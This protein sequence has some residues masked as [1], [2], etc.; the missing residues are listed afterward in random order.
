MEKFQTKVE[1]LIKDC[2]T[3]AGL[4]KPGISADDADLIVLSIPYDGESNDRKGSYLAPQAIR[5][6][7]GTVSPTNEYFESFSQCKILD[8]GNVNGENRDV[9]FKNTGEIIKKLI[10]KDKFFFVI[11]GDHSITIPVEK[12]VNDGLDEQF[13]IIHIDAHFDLCDSIGGDQLSHGSTQRRA[14]E[15][16]NIKNTD[17]IFFVGIRSIEL[18]EMD[19][20]YR[21]NINVITAR[22]IYLKGVESS[23]EIIKEK[24]S[25]FNKIY[26]TIDIDCLDIGFASGTGNPEAGGLTPRELLTLLR[27]IFEL[28]VIGFDIVGVAPELDPALS[29]VYAA[30]KII[31]ECFSHYFRKRGLLDRYINNDMN[32]TKINH[33][34]WSELNEY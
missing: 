18:D 12:A 20:Y 21:N 29:S 22:D 5:A 23:L 24:M 8:L 26:V 19:F 32:I 17:N 4:N 13:G 33:I 30:R 6:I 25:N 11:G 3:W 14:L 28:N 31:M 27:G 10:K 7:S 9:I 15:L 34:E 1:Q 2:K 16:S